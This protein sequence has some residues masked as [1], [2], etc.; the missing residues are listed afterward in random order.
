MVLSPL[1]SSGG[2]IRPFSSCYD[3]QP[4]VTSE[5]MTRCSFSHPAGTLLYRCR[6]L[7]YD[8]RHIK[9]PWTELLHCSLLIRHNA[10]EAGGPLLRDLEGGQFGE[11]SDIHLRGMSSIRVVPVLRQD[12]GRGS[13]LAVQGRQYCKVTKTSLDRAIAPIIQS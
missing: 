6:T 9:R 13:S 3:Y 12:P 2:E 4:W 5:S 8:N 11:F 7:R 1:C 10:M